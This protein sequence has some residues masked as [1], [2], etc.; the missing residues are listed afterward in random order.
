MNITLRD[1][2][3]FF[4]THII[5]G[6]EM[7]HELPFQVESEGVICY[8]EEEAENAKK[9]L[10]KL[11][12]SY[13]VKQL[14]TTSGVKEKAKG[15]KYASRS[16]AIK[17]LQEYIEPES[18]LIPNLIKRLEKAEKRNQELEAEITRVK[19]DVSAMKKERG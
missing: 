1:G 19:N 17:H 2:E 10:D 14:K 8:S 13:T 11:G 15:I 9:A 5:K 3:V 4:A 16:E 7:P 12:I 18:M 6:T